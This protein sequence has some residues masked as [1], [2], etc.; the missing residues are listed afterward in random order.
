[1]ISQGDVSKNDRKKNTKE[2]ISSQDIYKNEDEAKYL[3]S[4]IEIKDLKKRGL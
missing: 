2:K 4:D 3:Q 1:M